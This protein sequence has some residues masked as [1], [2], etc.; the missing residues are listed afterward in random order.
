MSREADGRS[1]LGYIEI[2]QKNYLRTRRQRSLIYDKVD[3]LLR[4]FQ[5][6][7]IDIDDHIKSQRKYSYQCIP[8]TE[9]LLNQIKNHKILF[10]KK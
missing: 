2:D 5:Q 4:Y 3:S 1:N 9:G 10:W 7:L 8:N 6:Q